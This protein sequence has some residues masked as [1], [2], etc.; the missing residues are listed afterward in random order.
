[1]LYGGATSFHRH[2]HRHRHVLVP[3]LLDGPVAME[4]WAGERAE[5]ALAIKLLVRNV[6]SSAR[7][8]NLIHVEITTAARADDIV[9]AVEIPNE[10]LQRAR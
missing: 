5:L 10:V 2:R 7:I 4:R 8:T 9:K 1:M 3:E 6:L